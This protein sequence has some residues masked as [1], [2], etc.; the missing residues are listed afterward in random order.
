[1]RLAT[2]IRVKIRPKAKAQ[3]RENLDTYKALTRKPT[4]LA[5]IKL[6]FRGATFIQHK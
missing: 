3:V 2:N 1:M 4:M 6:A 5:S